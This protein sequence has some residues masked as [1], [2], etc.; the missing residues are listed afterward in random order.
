[1]L[2][3]IFICFL[4]IVSPI[5]LAADDELKDNPLDPGLSYKYRGFLGLVV[6]GG[7]NIQNGDMGVWCQSCL[8]DNGRG[9]GY[10]IGLTYDH[11]IE[12]YLS[13]G[14]AVNYEDYSFEAKYRETS[15]REFE[16]GSNG[17][18]VRLPLELQQDAK[19]D[20][21]YIT[22]VPYVRLRPFELLSFRLG[23]MAS[24]GSPQLTHTENVINRIH[25][26]G[27]QLFVID[28]LRP[29]EN[30]DSGDVPP[31]ASTNQFSLFIA[32]NT[33][34]W[35]R[36]NLFLTGGIEWRQQITSYGFYNS[37]FTVTAPRFTLGLEY[38]I[39]REQ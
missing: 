20:L 35:L 31:D 21:Q 23:A 14:A 10:V 16:A 7:P 30:L 4:S 26:I 37:D 18:S 15:Y 11:Y 24:F 28:E 12:E 32:A 33:H 29:N 22:A 9:T 38:M 17:Q 6:G 2:R 3:T 8:F 1:M 39:Y 34:I 25:T 5:I 13:F 19:L 36:Y 27:G